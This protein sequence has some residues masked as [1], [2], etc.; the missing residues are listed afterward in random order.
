MKVARRSCAKVAGVEGGFSSS[1]ASYSGE[2]EC[3]AESRDG[4]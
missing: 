3:Q 4:G 2:E 1:A